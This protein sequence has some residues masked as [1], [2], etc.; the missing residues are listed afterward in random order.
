M[1]R[2]VTALA[3]AAILGGPTAV[4]FAQLSPFNQLPPAQTTPT[5]T[6]PPANNSSN[7]GGGGLKTWQELLM[8]G[9]GLAL[10]AGIG[11]II[12]R[13]ARQAAPVKAGGPETSGGG[14]RRSR[15]KQR[16]RARARAKAARRQR[17]RSR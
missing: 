3:A 6:A 9:G 14:T 17:R 13:D 11:M 10:L 7:G 8:F 16:A 12:V 5:V 15:E 2:R 4:A 1:K